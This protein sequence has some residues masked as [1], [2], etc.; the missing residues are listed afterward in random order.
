M[1]AI[2]IISIV[3]LLLAP[4][5][6]VLLI[7]SFLF[8]SVYSVGAVGFA[9]LTKHFFGVENYSTVYPIISFATN[10]GGAFAL[11]LVGYIYDFTGSYVYAFIIALTINVANLILLY[12]V[13]K[14]YLVA[15]KLKLENAVVNL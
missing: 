11:S 12:I 9:L 5:S 14:S 3:I 13:V 4:S 8:G 6:T 10:F 15:K 2:N 1:I 7:G